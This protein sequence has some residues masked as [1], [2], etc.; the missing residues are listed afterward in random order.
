ML[1]GLLVKGCPAASVI[2]LPNVTHISGRAFSMREDPLRFGLAQ[3]RLLSTVSTGGVAARS[4][5]LCSLQEVHGRS[6]LRGQ[7]LLI[8]NRTLGRSFENRFSVKVCLLFGSTC[9]VVTSVLRIVLAA[10]GR[11][12]PHP[13]SY[14]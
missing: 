6:D 12:S 7:E 14:E 2:E 1:A 11:A 10:T 5:E 9:L 13:W 4:I 8:C 3:A